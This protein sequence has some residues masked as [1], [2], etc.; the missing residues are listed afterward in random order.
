M[1]IDLAIAVIEPAG[2]RVLAI[3][4]A[5]RR[6]QPEP[7]RPAASISFYTSGGRSRGPKCQAK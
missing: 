5:L 7:K 2:K 4:R 6:P 1:L 3:L